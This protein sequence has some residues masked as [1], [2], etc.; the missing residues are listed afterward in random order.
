MSSIHHGERQ[1]LAQAKQQRF[2]NTTDGQVGVIKVNRR[3]EEVA[4]AV[5]PRGEVD[6]TVE[7]QELT[8]N[9]PTDPSKSPFEPQPYHEID[10]VTG[11]QKAYAEDEDMP[12]KPLLEVIDSKRPVPGRQPA[13]RG[14]R[15]PKEVVG[16]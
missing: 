11:E 3:G 10:E 4:I 16:A 8:A 7:E 14:R 5:P 1:A 6:L 9:A 2:R 12:R 15:S 13:T